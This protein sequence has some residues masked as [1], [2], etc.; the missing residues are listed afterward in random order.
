M[1][2]IHWSKDFFGFFRTPVIRSLKWPSL[3]VISKPSVGRIACS[4][5]APTN[6]PITA[7]AIHLLPWDR[8]Q[9]HSTGTGARMGHLDMLNNSRTAGKNN[10]DRRSGYQVTSVSRQRARGKEFYFSLDS[11]NDQAH[12]AIFLD[13]GRERT[14]TAS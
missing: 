12:Y 6:P 1:A 8:L 14:F 5:V 7:P 13:M 9:R 3:T 2:T 11:P 4:T 10:L